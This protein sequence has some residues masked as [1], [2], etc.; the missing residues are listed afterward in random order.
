[1][2]DDARARHLR[3]STVQLGA[4]IRGHLHDLDQRSAD[5]ESLASADETEADQAAADE[6][7]RLRRAAI[8]RW[9]D[10]TRLATLAAVGDLHRRADDHDVATSLYRA[11]L[12][13]DG[14]S[15]D[16]WQG[17]AASFR[18]KGRDDLA[19]EATQEAERI[20]LEG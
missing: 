18:A 9:P 17:L 6:A 19:G 2:I 12:D 16:A 4:A 14:G 8:A 11:H 7:C 5:D 1:M 20:L 10:A 13:L 15:A 3:T